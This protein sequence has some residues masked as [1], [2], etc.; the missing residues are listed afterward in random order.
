MHSA[1]KLHEAGSRLGASGR[2]PLLALSRVPPRGLSGPRPF[3]SARAV[4]TAPTDYQDDD[5]C[6]RIES[7]KEL[8]LCLG[9][10]KPATVSEAVSRLSALGLVRASNILSG[11]CVVGTRFELIDYRKSGWP[12]TRQGKG[13][14]VEVARARGIDPESWWPEV[15]D[16]Q[17]TG[18]TP[19]NGRPPKK[20]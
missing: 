12:E 18:G 2:A 4:G 20:G 10:K 8:A 9:I 16:I 15:G 6:C 5:G 7:Y 17:K 14:W 19:K 1:I 3:T 13:V 11:R